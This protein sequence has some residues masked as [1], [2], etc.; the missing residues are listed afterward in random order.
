[1][2][3]D[4]YNE[5]GITDWSCWVSGAPASANCAQANGTAYAVAGMAT[6]LQA[7]RN[8]GAPNV[9]ILGGLS[10]SQDFSSWVTSVNS[11]P[12]LPAPLDGISIDNVAA[13]WH[14]YSFNSVYTQCPSQFNTNAT[15][16]GSAQQFAASSS[17]T[18]V[19]SAG[20][21]VVIGEM[22]ISAYSAA[23]AAS[24]S[25]VQLTALETWLDAV[26]TYME[27]QGQGYLAWSWDL[28]QN[29]VL[30][31]DFTTG[32]PTPYFG[33]TYQKHLQSTF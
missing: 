14:A 24:Y 28:A 15:T 17:I 25:A 1:V 7:V 11:I 22:G 19:M 16:C 33:V 23:T 32:A 5:P 2:I 29:P 26:M 8:A 18:D 27:G 31:T 21:P 3:Y 13:S 10:L 30:I 6:M 9:V 20:F 4:L 12:T